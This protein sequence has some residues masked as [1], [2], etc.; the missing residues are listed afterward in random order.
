MQQVC[1]A[2]TSSCAMGTF[3]FSAAVISC[4]C[5]AHT[6]VLCTLTVVLCGRRQRH[7]LHCQLHRHSNAVVHLQ[8]HLHRHINAFVHL[9]RSQYAVF[10]GHAASEQ[11]SRLPCF[12]MERHAQPPGGAARPVRGAH[13][14]SAARKLGFKPGFKLRARRRSLNP[15]FNP[16]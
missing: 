8:R 15:G 4:V 10:C 16:G 7:H 5:S 3:V 2:H 13:C 9:R 1:S 11:L 6:I 12:L 14:F